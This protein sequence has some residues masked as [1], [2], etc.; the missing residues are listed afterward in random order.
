[1]AVLALRP[2]RVCPAE[3]RV[4]VGYANCVCGGYLAVEVVCKELSDGFVDEGPLV[5]GQVGAAC[6]FGW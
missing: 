2:F 1:M 6:D 3:S 5:F 4:C